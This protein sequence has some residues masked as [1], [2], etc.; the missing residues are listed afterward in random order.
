[1]LLPGI[2][3]A[4]L[5]AFIQTIQPKFEAQTIDSNISIGY[6]LAL[7]DVDGDGKPDIL[8]ADKKQFVWYRNGDW[9][10][11]VMAENLTE[12][13]NVCIAARDINGD[14]KVE[15]AVGAQ[16]NPSETGN[17]EQSGAVYYLSRPDDPTQLWK[18]IELYHEPTIHR[19]QWYRS[20]EGK[21]YLIVAPLHGIG[22]KNGEGAGVNILIFE[23][24]R[25]INA[26]WQ[27]HKLASNMHLTHNFEILE[28]GDKSK[29]GFY[30]AG[31]EGIKFIHE[32]SFTGQNLV[33]DQLP[34]MDSAAG[35]VRIGKNF[36]KQKFM[37]AIEPMH[38]S[39]LVI[40]PDD[41]GDQR[42]VLD[43]NLRE[44]HAVATGVFLGYGS[45]QVVAG[46]RVPNKD[47]LVGIKLFVE[48]NVNKS[49]WDSYWI[50]KNGMACEDIKVLDLDQ[51]G[52][53]DIIASG[54]STHNLKIY[55]NRT[56][57]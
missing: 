52:K 3:M 31:K 14:G 28:S 8:L 19:M 20:S 9:K 40:Y 37:V 2:Y 5:L 38:G 50:D 6:G 30:L 29:S 35:E 49:G 43:D 36:S 17:A 1:M 32:A 24:P 10:K 55:W 25:D 42:K 34:G 21:I 57:K 45:D 51:D 44:G 27:V 23:Y 39:N 26:E 12:H 41:A 13:D 7:G 4:V 53:P 22:N 48:K 56:V 46:W 18:A 16:W 15:V 47:S 54:R 11:F 33:I